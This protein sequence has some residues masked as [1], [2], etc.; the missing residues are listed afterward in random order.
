[1][2]LMR[3]L[4]RTG[5][6]K[7]KTIEVTLKRHEASPVRIVA[8]AAIATMG[9]L[10][11]RLVPLIILDTSQRPDIEELIR[12][13]HASKG[14]GDVIHQWVR[15]EGHEDAC[16]LLLKFIRPLEATV[17]VEFKI[18]KQGVLIDQVLRGRGLYIQ[19]GRKGDRFAQD[20]G[21]PKVLIEVG[22][23]GFSESW[24]AIF[25]Q[26]LALDF[27]QKG[28]NRHDSLKAA[29]EAIGELRKLFSL[30]MPDQQS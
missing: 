4:S 20:L 29:A 23:T 6:A 8:D 16:A 14:P 3:F 9:A 5:R 11:G 18:V 2:R 7:P 24:E 19:A 13:H 17:V 28:L 15:I 26:N 25:H 10:G 1:M 27:Q 12:V 22:D 30:R 21:R